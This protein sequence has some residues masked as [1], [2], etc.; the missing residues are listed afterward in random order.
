MSTVT[1]KLLI[2]VFVSTSFYATGVYAE[3]ILSCANEVATITATTTHLTDNNNG[4]ITDPETGLRWKKCSE[5]QRWSATDNN[6]TGIAEKYTWQAALQR[7]QTINTGIG[8]NFSQFDWRLPNI[9]ELASIVELR[10]VDLAINDTVFP[11]TPTDFFWS[12]STYSYDS[13]FARFVDFSEGYDNQISRDRS[14]Q[15]RLVR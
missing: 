5:G 4:T 15:V 13:R 11:N 12:S 7:A 3:N 9:K 2:G 8:E 1:K 6:C 14:L 10:C